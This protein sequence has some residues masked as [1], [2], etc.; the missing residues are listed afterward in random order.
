MF[1]DEARFGRMVHAPL[2]VPSASPPSVSN[3]YEREFVYVYGAVSPIEGDMDWMISQKMNAEQMTLFLS[4]VS[5]AHPE[6]F[7]V[8]VLDGASSHKAKDL[9]GPTTSGS[10]PCPSMPLNSTPRSI[11][12]MSFERNSRTGSSTT[13][14]P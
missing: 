13:S 12:G 2:L 4:Q 6:D 11:Y 9:G 7:I 10:S 14:P 1:Q 8:M 5:A 3:G